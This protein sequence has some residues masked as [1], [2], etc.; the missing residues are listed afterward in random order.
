MPEERS[1]HSSLT[2]EMFFA[3]VNA[4]TSRFQTIGD[5]RKV[6]D[7]DGL[8]REYERILRGLFE[9]LE[10]YERFEDNVRDVMDFMPHDGHYEALNAALGGIRAS[11]PASESGQSLGRTND[12]TNRGA[13]VAVPRRASDSEE[14]RPAST[15]EAREGGEGQV[16]TIRE[17]LDMLK[18]WNPVDEFPDEAHA[19]LTQLVEQLQS[20]QQEASDMRQAAAGMS[21]DVTR[22]GEQL[23]ALR[24]IAED[25]HKLMHNSGMEA[26]AR[27]I[28]K[29]I[30]EAVSSPASTPEARE[31]TA[32]VPEKTTTYSSP[33]WGAGGNPEQGE[34][35][36]D[37]S[38][39]SEREPVI[40]LRSAAEHLSSRL[41]LNPNPVELENA[42]DLLLHF[43]TRVDELIEQVE[44]L[45]QLNDRVIA[46]RDSWE[47]ECNGLSEQLESAQR[48]L[49][50]LVQTGDSGTAAV[51][52]AALGASAS[53]PASEPSDA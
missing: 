6:V 43:A 31:R 27:S 46:E 20:A 45:R 42:A 48:A 3:L 7:Q 16:Q 37:A 26:L 39:H 10:A 44:T 36:K 49:W 11:N 35:A 19:A 21:A 4:V 1:P 18:V 40:T 50:H 33:R 8:R 51:A 47:R 2:D 12:S 25:Y 15:P 53:N 38:A 29:Q 14:P 17:A 13:E 52:R 41:T 32:K 23:E 5:S 30:D 9:Q 24:Q 22:L 34:W 28:R